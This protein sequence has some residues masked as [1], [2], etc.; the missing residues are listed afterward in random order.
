MCVG[1]LLACDVDGLVY[2]VPDRVGGAAGSAVQVADASAL[3]RRLT[4]VSGILGADALELIAGA[5]PVIT[6]PARALRA[7]P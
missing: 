3:P 6:A 4:V 1:A 2:A 5:S 7:A